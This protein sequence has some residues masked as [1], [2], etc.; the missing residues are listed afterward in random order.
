MMNKIR[1]KMILSSGAVGFVISAMLALVS[2]CVPQG[3]A[4]SVQ[5]HNTALDYGWRCA[6]AITNDA[7][8]L[9]DRGQAQKKIAVAYLAA[10]DDA[11]ALACAVQIE[12]W[13][14]G[15]ALAEIAEWL[16]STGSTAKAEAMLP[17]LEACGFAAKDWQ[18]EYL[19]SAITH[20][21]ARLGRQ[22]SVIDSAA[23]FNSK[24]TLGG[25]VAASLALVL[26][27]T[28][29]VSEATGILS[30]LSKTNG[31]DTASSSVRGYL[32]LVI[33]GQLTQN[34]TTQMIMNAWEA[35]REV[36][37][38]RRWEL[39]LKVV[40]AMAAHDMS[41]TAARCLDEVASK[42]VSATKLPAEIQ[43]S[44]LSQ[45]VILWNR[46]GNPAK[47]KAL[48][49]AAETSIGR[50]LDVIFQPFA[51]AKLAEAYAVSGDVVKAR[52][53]Y[54][55]ALDIAANLVNR[56]PRAIAG[57]EVCVSLAEH[58]EVID[59]GIQKALDRLVGTFNAAQP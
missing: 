5:S 29:R 55:R 10:G 27:R 50:R 13:S 58:K 26:A 54:G 17:A 11:T 15:M 2:G 35:T 23:K 52:S 57:V 25:D 21:Q 1:G 9:S 59:A 20:L 14:K 22:N 56:R 49:D 16:V 41:E 34:T 28:G 46:M 39:Q 48:L 3:G 31:L 51:Y 4:R 37:P 12:D 8:D 36:K 53:L 24:S 44:L 43:V 7:I 30:N 6:C 45:G 42:V 40:E 19:R 33:A 38:Y 47:S 32:D 18:R